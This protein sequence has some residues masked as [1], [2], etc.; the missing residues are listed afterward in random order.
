MSKIDP[1][2]KLFNYA[3]DKMYR[4]FY[5]TDYTDERVMTGLLINCHGS[6]LIF[7]GE[8]GMYYIKH[9]DVLFMEP[10]PMP[11]NL[12]DNFRTLIETY[13]KEEADFRRIK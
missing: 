8:K 1:M 5:K 12:S 7:L 6:F 13:L 3:C 9:K 11:K 4:V 10:I 2:Y